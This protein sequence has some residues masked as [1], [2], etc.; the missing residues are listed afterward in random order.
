MEKEE[1]E[2]THLYFI[3]DRLSK[4]PETAVIQS[5]NDATAV[6]G[7]EAFLK[8][9]DLR[10]DEQ[11]VPKISP[12]ERELVHICALDKDN[13]IIIS[14]E[15]WLYGRDGSLD[16]RDYR[17]VTSGDKVE[18]YLEEVRNG[19]REGGESDGNI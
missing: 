7:F 9:D 8:A 13:R 5:L 18:S 6:R 1:F 11:K 2:C 15:T 4:T 17:V 19:L 10:R 14:D 16:S 3:R 12:V